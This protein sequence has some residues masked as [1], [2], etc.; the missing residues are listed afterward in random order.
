[1]KNLYLLFSFAFF[2]LPFQLNSQWVQA[3]GPPGGTINA[4]TSAGSNLYAG[5]Y[6]TGV[7]ISTNNGVSWNAV[8]SGLP[9]YYYIY[10][11]CSIGSNVFAGIYNGGVY[12]ST[13]NG[14]SWQPVNNGLTNLYVFSV[15]SAGSNVYAGTQAGPFLSTNTGQ[16]WTQINSGIGT[17]TVNCFTSYGSFIF[18][19]TSGNGVYISSNNGTSWTPINSGLTSSQ[20]SSLINYPNGSG[21]TLL[22]GTRGWGVFLSTN[23]GTQWTQINSG[24]TDLSV[25]SLVAAS[26]G[27]G[28]YNIFAGTSG[29]GVFMSPNASSW[30]QV[31]TGLYENNILSL[32]A[33]GSNVFAGGNTNGVFVSTNSGTSWAS[34]N[35]GLYGT[36]V[37]ALLRVGQY[38]FTGEFGGGGMFI[39][40]NNGTSWNIGGLLNAAISDFAISTNGNE[41]YASTYNNG[42]GMYKSTNYGAAWTSI[43]IGLSSYEAVVGAANNGYLFTGGLSGIYRSTNDGTSWQISNNGIDCNS[44]YSIA[45]CGSRMLVGTQYCSNGGGLFVSSDYG[46]TWVHT[47]F[48]ASLINA[49][50][51][52]PDGTGRNN[53]YAING[54]FFGGSIWLSLDS[55]STFT[56]TN[57]GPTSALCI[58]NSGTTIF[59]G[60][61]G[62]GVYFTTNNGA[63][64]GSD[65][66]GLG[67]LRIKSIAADSLYVYAGTI[68]NSIWKLPISQ[69]TGIHSVSNEIPDGFILEQ[70][71]PN[72]FNPSTNIK[73]NIP[74]LRGVAE[75]RGVSVKL[76]VYDILGKEAVTLVNE[77][78]MHGSY[79]VNW[80]GTNFPSG[81]YFYKLVVGDP[82]EI[83]TG[84]TNKGSFTETKKMVLLK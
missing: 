51:T 43:A 15:Y 32:F 71:Y 65:N 75:S 7:Y 76:K 37:V 64:W 70:N 30:T 45:S 14:G 74:L 4:F 56:L 20:V 41:L 44:I 47:A 3:P 67:N 49:I 40:T 38:I 58:A 25:Q 34:A 61:N 22:A 77:N 9:Q 62:Q 10:A 35:N 5:V 11:L 66:T 52:V 78:K 63:S 27:G 42:S 57:G 72:P 59:A 82:R 17:L 6:G 24:L 55:G 84:N 73:F 16:S 21:N 19:G 60:T 2:L 79:S 29:H 48:G 23:N 69:I 8:N 13:N 46:S 81:V 53:V 83:G 28:G 26:N 36:D 18:A 54:G 80:D 33:I 50:L 39:S 68:Y 12:L 1:M 31:N